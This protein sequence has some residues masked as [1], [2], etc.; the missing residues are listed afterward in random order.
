MRKEFEEIIKK[1]EIQFVAEDNLRKKALLSCTDSVQAKA[2][3]GELYVE[4]DENNSRCPDNYFAFCS[5]FL[6]CAHDVLGDAASAVD[7]AID[8]VEQFRRCG[9]DTNEALAH[10][11]LGILYKSQNDEHLAYSELDDAKR[12][13]ARKTE[14]FDSQGDYDKKK[15]IVGYLKKINGLLKSM[16]Q[17]VA[18]NP[19]PPPRPV[20]PPSWSSAR[21]TVGVHDIGH[22]SKVG[23]FVMDDAIISKAEVE[24]LKFDN[25]SYNIYNLRGGVD[26]KLNSAN[27]YRWLKVAGVSMNRANPIPIEPGNFI[28]VNL[29]I[30]PQ[31]GDIIVARFKNPP[32]KEE[33][34]GAVKRYTVAGL[35]SES[36]LAIPVISLDEIELR[37]VVI[38]VAKPI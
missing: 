17:K 32:T 34:A 13:F 37:G 3:I 33:R 11:L 24:N 16:G 1:L 14:E 25:I 28:L 22:A 21:L 18:V 10:W 20:Q 27:E 38:A 26:V 8:S 36:R 12:L 6:A 7:A 31:I 19:K 2:L 15:R 23:I 30:A 29:S 35:A 4:N 9:N 5:L